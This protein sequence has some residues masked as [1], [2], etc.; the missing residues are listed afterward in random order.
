MEL[1]N[2]ILIA[3]AG[4]NVGK[5]TL[6]C[7]LIAKLSQIDQVTAVKV[8]PHRHV[9][10]DKQKVLFESEGLII[11]EETDDDSSKDSSR[12]LRAGAT[13]SLFVLVHDDRIE[14]LAN[15]LKENI[16]GWM[17]CESG[18]LGNVVVPQRAI[19]VDSEGSDKTPNWDFP[20]MTTVFRNDQFVPNVI[21]NL[22]ISI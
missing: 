15:W 11:S 14:I 16:K 12:Y 10:T 9:L 6:C 4:R 17:V 20:F 3:G 7:R 1:K 21:D 18:Y 5:T 13:Q 19:F 2:L 8:S 22:S